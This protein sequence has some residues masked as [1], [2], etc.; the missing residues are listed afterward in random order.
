MSDVA[1]FIRARLDEHEEAARIALGVNGVA[2][3]QHHLRGDDV[4]PNYPL[5][6]WRYDAGQ[7]WQTHERTPTIVVGQTWGADGEHIALNDPVHVLTWVAAM[8][9]ILKQFE[10]ASG[11]PAWAEYERGQRA[12][13][14]GALRAFAAAWRFHPDYDP[15]WAPAPPH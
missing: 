3:V 10:D 8:R 2:S 13:L 6:R 4:A 7:V 1:A 5:P 12:A 14:Q 11:A 9:A 15:A